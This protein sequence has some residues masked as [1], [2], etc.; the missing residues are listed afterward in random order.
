MRL[1]FLGFACLTADGSAR[2]SPQARLC[3]VAPAR[4]TRAPTSK[5]CAAPLPLGPA[6][7]WESSS[8]ADHSGPT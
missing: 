6:N 5:R 8:C 7:E 4:P 2:A 1:A 3:T